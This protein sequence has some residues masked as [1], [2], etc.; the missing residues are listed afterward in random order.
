MSKKK[1]QLPEVLYVSI[2]EEGSSDEFLL[3]QGDWKD[4][5]KIGENVVVV[6]I[7]W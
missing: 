4:H 1:S 3:T 5:A 6:S 2:E 7:G